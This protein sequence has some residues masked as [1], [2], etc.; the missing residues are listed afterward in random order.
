MEIEWRSTSPLE[1]S[2][3]L[4]ETSSGHKLDVSGAIGRLDTWQAMRSRLERF[5]RCA[6]EL[7]RNQ[8]RGVETCPPDPTRHSRKKSESLAVRSANCAPRL[9][10][11]SRALALIIAL[12]DTLRDT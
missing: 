3:F 8:S 12:D 2:D 11:N 9:L 4:S 7:V 10:V 6:L 1:E 5:D